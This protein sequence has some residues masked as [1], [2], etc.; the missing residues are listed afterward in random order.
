MKQL[1]LFKTECQHEH[2]VPDYYWDGKQNCVMHKCWKCDHED[3]YREKDMKSIPGRVIHFE[4]RLY[5]PSP[6]MELRIH[7]TSDKD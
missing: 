7:G 6:E 3:H 4:A 5:N 1:S 2:I